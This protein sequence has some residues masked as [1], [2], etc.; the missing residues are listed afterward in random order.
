MAEQ[1]ATGPSSGGGTLA[2]ARDRSGVAHFRRPAA[3]KLRLVI[4]S[5][6]AFLCEGLVDALERDAAIEVAATASNL[7]DAVRLVSATPTDM[8]VIDTSVPGG[9]DIAA[10]LHQSEP[11]ARLVALGVVESAAE[12]L[13]WAT[14]GVSGYVPRTTGMSEIAQALKEIAR[15]EQSGSSSVMGGLLHWIASG[16]DAQTGRDTSSALTLREQQVAALIDA[17]L[18]NKE[19]ARHLNIGLATTKSHVHNLLGKLALARRSQVTGRL[20]A[21][22]AGRFGGAGTERLGG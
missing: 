20:R 7:A 2:Q 3:P 13:P 17:G 16:P 10:A 1:S 8:V 4:V 5:D 12:I 9:P 15:G 11:L 21:R 18:S 14:A 22:D 6:I 19:I